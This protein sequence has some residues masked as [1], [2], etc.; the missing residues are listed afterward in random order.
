[1]IAPAQL[2]DPQ[3]QAPRAPFRWAVSL[4]VTR[5]APWPQRQGERGQEEGDSTACF[6]SAPPRNF[7]CVE[8][9]LMH[10]SAEQLLHCCAETGSTVTHQGRS[11]PGKASL[12]QG[13]GNSW[14]KELSL[15]QWP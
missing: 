11:H 10:S 3:A 9:W 4:Q 7:F 13:T 15:A 8:Q 12:P 1:M 6:P 5:L 14:E 2:Q